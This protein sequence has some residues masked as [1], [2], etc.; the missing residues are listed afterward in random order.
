MKSLQPLIGEWT[1]EASLAPDMVGRAVFEWTLD[2]QFLTQRL[3][4]PRPV[5]DGFT[6]IG[7]APDGESFTQ[8][9]FDSR[10][11]VR[12]YAMTFTDGVWTLLRDAPDFT[13]LDFYQRYI[14]TVGDDSIIGRWEQSP[15]GTNWELDFHLNYS[16][17]K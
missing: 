10:G 16:R 5:P 8:H 11:V 15:D 7:R 2:E 6:I 13:P 14:G 4:A 1:M 12:V 3:E 9:Y 17:V